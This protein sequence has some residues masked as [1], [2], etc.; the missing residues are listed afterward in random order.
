METDAE[1]ALT[2][3]RQT[4]EGVRSQRAMIRHYRSWGRDMFEIRSAFGEVDEYE[5]ETLL[6]DNL[7]LPLG[8]VARHGSF[9]V[10]VHKGCLEDLSVDAVLFL[11]TRIGLLA[12]LLEGRRGGD[13]F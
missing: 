8:A 2:L 13:R 10:L 1:I 7:R 12:D 3:E 6:S 11:L 4:E 5:P 9:L